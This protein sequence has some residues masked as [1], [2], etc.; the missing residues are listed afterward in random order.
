MYNLYDLKNGGDKE[1]LRWF[2]FLQTFCYFMFITYILK[3]LSVVVITATS[4]TLPI[5]LLPYY[6]SDNHK[7]HNTSLLSTP[8]TKF[9]HRQHPR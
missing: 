1:I 3:S 6:K 5:K 2:P 9:P 7:L 8:I 4:P